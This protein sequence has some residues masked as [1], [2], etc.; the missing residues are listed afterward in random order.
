MEG[1]TARI[2]VR[3]SLIALDHVLHHVAVLGGNVFGRVTED[4]RHVDDGQ[5]I[6][7]GAP[8]FDF[9]N[10]FGKGMGAR[11]VGFAANA[12]SRVDLAPKKKGQKSDQSCPKE[13]PVT[14]NIPRSR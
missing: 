1:R 3:S 2:M 14:K 9:E 6:F 13:I 12:H 4:A 7:V 5:V 8:L 10:V 11:R